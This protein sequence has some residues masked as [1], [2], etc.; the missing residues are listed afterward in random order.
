MRYGFGADVGGTTVKLGF[1]DETGK[2]LESREIPTRTENCGEAIL[3]DIAAAVGKIKG[4]KKLIIFSAETDNCEKNAREKMAKKNADMVVLNDVTKP[5]AGFNTDTNIVT[6]ITKS[7]KEELPV[8]EKSAL[9]DI[10][11][12]RI[13]EL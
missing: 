11:L 3:P 7:T 9:A 4:N 5:G 1:F 8:M 6:I 10:L 13:I 12:D 2:R